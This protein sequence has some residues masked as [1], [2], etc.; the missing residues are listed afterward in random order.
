MAVGRPGALAAFYV[1]SMFATGIVTWF[2][3]PLGITAV[4][5]GMCIC[6]FVLLLAGQY[7]LLSRVVGVPMRDSF[8]DSAAALVSSGALLAAMLPVAEML[9]ASLGP[10]PLTLLIAPLGLAVYAAC[11]RVAS[12]GAWY[13]LGKLFV[14]VLGARRVVTTAEPRRTAGLT[15][16][17]H[18]D[19]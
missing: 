16:H 4:S 7:F 15:P 18:A 10:L 2:T 19:D 12:P 8:R 11:L 14:R 13:D 9:R 17:G 3:A 1:A 6:Q 5:L